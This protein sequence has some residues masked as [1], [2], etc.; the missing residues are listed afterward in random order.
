[1]TLKEEGDEVPDGVWEALWCPA[2]GST[3]FARHITDGVYCDGC[4]ADMKFVD[5]TDV[6]ASVVFRRV[7]IEAIRS[8]DAQD[9]ET[10]VSA[11]LI[12]KSDGWKVAE[13]A[14]ADDDFAPHPPDMS[15]VDKVEGTELTETDRMEM[16]N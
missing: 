11:R 2:C 6:F 5:R 8:G 7:S 14:S 16:W 15:D 13:W 12:R 10:A 1:M 9:I 4:G 3:G